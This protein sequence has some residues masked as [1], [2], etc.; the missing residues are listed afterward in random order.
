MCAAAK[1]MALTIDQHTTPEQ[2]RREVVKPQ[3][4]IDQFHDL[5][6]G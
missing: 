5:Q 3:R 2:R 1:T 6:A 4:F